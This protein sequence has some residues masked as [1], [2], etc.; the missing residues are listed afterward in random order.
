MNAMAANDPNSTKLI[1]NSITKRYVSFQKRF[2]LFHTRDDRPERTKQ[3]TKEF[4]NW[5]GYDA[6]ILIGS[7]TSLAFQYLKTY[8]QVDVPIY[9]W[10]HM[11][12]DVIFESLLAILPK[13]AL[14]FG[15]GNIV[16]LGMDLSLYLKNR[17]EQIYE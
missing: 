15:I 13:Q 12:L 6:V 8:S 2:I 3:L 11:N 10:E 9:V 5:E 7:S 4:A 17:S 1:W 14:V 16:G